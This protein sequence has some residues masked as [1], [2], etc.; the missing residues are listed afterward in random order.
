MIDK[1]AREIPERQ[2]YSVRKAAA[3]L[4]AEISIQE[5]LSAQGVEVLRNRAQCIVHGG[6]NPTSFSIDPER[7]LWHCHACNDGGDL[8]GLAEVVEKHADTWTAVVSLSQRFNIKLPVKSQGWHEWQDEKGRRRKVLRN[9]I[10]ASYQRRLF[11]L[12]RDDIELIEDPDE[13]KE[14]ARAIWESIRP[15]AV[16]CAERRMQQ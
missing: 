6:D 3:K 7:Q 12:F 11:R 16:S 4:K 1:L 13:R 14:E 2:R 10:A 5:Y 15:L 8:I 9:T